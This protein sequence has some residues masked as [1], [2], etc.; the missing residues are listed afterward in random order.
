MTQSLRS[1][2]LHICSEI[3]YR[4]QMS[5]WNQYMEVARHCFMFLLFRSRKMGWPIPFSEECFFQFQMYIFPKSH[6]G[7]ICP[8]LA[9]VWH[10]TGATSRRGSIMSIHS[11]CIT[12]TVNT[13]TFYYIYGQYIHISLHLLSKHSHFITFMVKTLTYHYIYCQNIHILLHLLSIHSHLW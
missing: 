4:Y 8:A 1:S 10:L 12:F 13:F 6:K 11:R 5:H 2:F 7:W 9:S 3:H